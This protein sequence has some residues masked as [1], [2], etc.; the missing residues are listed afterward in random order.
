LLEDGAR[1]YLTKPI[2]VGDLLDVVDTHI[3]G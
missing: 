3:A 2:G 1:A